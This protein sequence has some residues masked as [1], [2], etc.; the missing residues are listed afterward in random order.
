MPRG[1]ES[2]DQRGVGVYRRRCRAWD[3]GM[4][5]GFWFFYSGAGI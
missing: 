2:V 1:A 3:M 4:G 5:H